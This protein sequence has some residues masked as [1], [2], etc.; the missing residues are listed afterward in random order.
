MA[1]PTKERHLR[2]INIIRYM[3]RSLSIELELHKNQTTNKTNKMEKLNKITENDKLTMSSR[4]IAELT[5]KN[6]ADVMRDIRKLN[7]NYEKLS[8]SKIADG[9]FLH[10]KTGNQQHKEYNLTQIQTLDLMTGYNIELRIKVNRR[11]QELETEKQEPTKAVSSAEFL[12]QSAQLMVKYEKTLIKHDKRLIDLEE[13]GKENLKNLKRLPI[14]NTPVPD[15]STKDKVRMMVNKYS[16]ATKV[17]Y[18]DIWT[19]LYDDLYYRYNISI[20]SYKKIKDTESKINVA[21]RVDVI[22]N[23]LDIISSYIKKANISL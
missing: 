16:A 10:P 9:Y 19:K 12:L 23:M 1:A 8:L 14:S 2:N 7:A 17:P 22:D 13:M 15:I 18:K 20:N 4:E 6:H 5:N 3:L 21:V 11:W